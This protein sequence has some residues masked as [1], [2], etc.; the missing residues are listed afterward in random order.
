MTHT[1]RKW[2]SKQNI[3]KIYTQ[4][5]KSSSCAC[6]EESAAECKKN[7]EHSEIISLQNE[8]LFKS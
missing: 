8:C 4:Y 1:R 5:N 3:N 2:R 6:Y 7:M